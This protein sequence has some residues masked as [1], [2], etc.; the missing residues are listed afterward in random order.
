M[1]SR[2]ALAAFGLG[3]GIAG[4]QGTFVYDQQST[5]ASDGGTVLSQTPFGQSF[6]PAF[7]SIDFVQFYLRDPL[8]ASIVEINLRSTS[9]TGPILGTT[10]PTTLNPN[11][12]GYV[13]FLFSNRISLAPGTKYFLEPVGIGGGVATADLTFVQYPGGDAIYNGTVFSDRDFLFR[14]GIIVPEPSSWALLAVG[15]G[16]FFWKRHK[17]RR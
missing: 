14:E 3:I 1:K 7:D 8:N 13:D 15:M 2:I 9:I 10:T 17:F 12:S 11:S 5:G 4:A 6:T 16:A